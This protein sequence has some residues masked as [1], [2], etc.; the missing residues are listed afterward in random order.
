MKHMSDSLKAIEA[1]G[2]KLSDTDKT[3]MQMGE[4]P[5]E[6]PNYL[7][8][9]KERAGELYEKFGADVTAYEK[10][11]TE[12]RP[13][14]MAISTIT[15]LSSMKMP[16]VWVLPTTTNVSSTRLSLCGKRTRT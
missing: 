10:Y 16:K 2:G 8:Y 14:S 1:A 7:E 13:Y 5:Q 6:V 4:H 15:G 9:V 12:N 11:Y 3:Y